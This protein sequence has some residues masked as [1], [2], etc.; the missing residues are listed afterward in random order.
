MMNFQ[1]ILD[2]SLLFHLRILHHV[3]SF[4]L[5]FSKSTV[6]LLKKTI[7]KKYPKHRDEFKNPDN[8]PLISKEQ[9]FDSQVRHLKDPKVVRIC[10]IYLSKDHDPFE[11]DLYLQ[12]DTN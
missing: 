8:S 1:K 3:P 6:Q 12:S 2:F 4:S 5:N 9:F 10:G 7:Y 11:C